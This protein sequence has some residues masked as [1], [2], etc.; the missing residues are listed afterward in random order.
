MNVNAVLEVKITSVCCL[1]FTFLSDEVSSA[2]RLPQPGSMSL[3]VSVM[4]TPAVFETRAKK[5][6][7]YE[8]SVG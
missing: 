7:K 3:F 5:K 8:R 6:M 2:A 4:V 1:V